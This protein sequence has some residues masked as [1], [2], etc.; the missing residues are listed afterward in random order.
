[1]YHGRGQAV[2]CSVWIVWSQLLMTSHKVGQLA[3]FLFPVEDKRASS[4]SLSKFRPLGCIVLRE[5]GGA[6]ICCVYRSDGVTA[7]CHTERRYE[8][9][10]GEMLEMTSRQDEQPTG[11]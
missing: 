7:S 5:K 2:A 10:K 9:G 11:R 3:R 8:Q 4:M 6:G 1:M